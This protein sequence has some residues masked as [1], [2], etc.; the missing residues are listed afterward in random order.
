MKSPVV[1]VEKSVSLREVATVMI[2]HNVGLVVIVDEKGRVFGV[3]SERDFVRF[4]AQGVSPDTRVEQV[5]SR[6]VVKISA[7]EPLC[8]AAELMQRHGV[9]HLVVVDENERPL[10]VVSVRDL[11]DVE[12]AIRSIAET[13]SVIGEEDEYET[14]AHPFQLKVTC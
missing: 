11:V 6:P 13:V 12:H 5:A 4:A 8:K 2:K 14:L 9:K 1:T 3:V 10:G 7:D